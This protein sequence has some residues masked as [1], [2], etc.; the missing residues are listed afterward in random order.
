[1]TNFPALLA[2]LRRPR[3]LIRAARFGLEDYRREKDLRRLLP[4]A[5]PDRPEQI[6]SCLMA[7]EEDLEIRRREGDAGYSLARHIEVLIAL[8]SEVRLLPQDRRA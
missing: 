7:V 2:S 4:K 1:M 5:A 6:M 8:M 3:L